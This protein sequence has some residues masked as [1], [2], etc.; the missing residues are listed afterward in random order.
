VAAS[1]NCS[2]AGQTLPVTYA[3][4][5]EQIVGLDQVNML[6]PQSLAGTGL[7]SVTCQFQSIPTNAVSVYIR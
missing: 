3:G 6:L 4:P 5:Q 2:I 1:S 7:T